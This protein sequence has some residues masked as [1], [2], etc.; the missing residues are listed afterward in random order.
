MAITSRSSKCSL[1]DLKM[2]D[3]IELTC[4]GVLQCNNCAFDR[5]KYTDQ[6]CWNSKCGRKISLKH[7]KPVL[8]LWDIILSKRCKKRTKPFYCYVCGK[9]GHRTKKCPTITCICCHEKGHAE[10]DCPNKAKNTVHKVNDTRGLNVDTLDMNS[11]SRTSDVKPPKL[12]KEVVIFLEIV[13]FSYND[14]VQ[15][16]QLGAI[17]VHQTDNVDY[18]FAPVS[19]NKELMD[20]YPFYRH[21]YTW[22]EDLKTSYQRHDEGFDIACLTEKKAL[23]EFIDF[24]RN[25]HQAGMKIN[26][27]VTSFQSIWN[28]LLHRLEFYHLKEIFLCEFK[29]KVCDLPL[30]LEN[31]SDSSIQRWR[32]D[33]RV[34]I[35]AI[36]HKVT[37]QSLISD[38]SADTVAKAI[39]CLIESLFNTK[40]VYKCQ[41]FIKAFKVPTHV[42][43]P[44]RVFHNSI[45]GSLFKHTMD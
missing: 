15:V 44:L 22:D 32:H 20:K 21:Q 45:Q 25:F 28:L 8:D 13:A 11:N 23:E 5:I 10:I 40:N 19:V 27:F 12:A 29:P 41:D 42:G 1:C 24:C 39:W 36:Y 7:F 38:M 35:R 6:K 3:P 31:N 18:L 14:H 16:Y 43:Y 2:E 37:G 33:C 9:N 34:H 30:I 4:C 17:A 26:I